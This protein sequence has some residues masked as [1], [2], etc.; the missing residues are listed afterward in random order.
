MTGSHSRLV[1]VQAVVVALLLVLVF[2]TLL[3]PES[4]GPIEAVQG[5]AG[6]PSALPGPDVYTG[7]PGNGPSPPPGRTPGGPDAPGPSG[8]PGG[9]AVPGAPGSAGEPTDTEGLDLTDPE[10]PPED[11][12]RPDGGPDDDQYLSA[13]GRLTQGLQ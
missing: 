10:R 7:D 13:L 5:P 2:A 9:A 4:E 11:E 8:G 1:A 3:E 12:T 6:Q